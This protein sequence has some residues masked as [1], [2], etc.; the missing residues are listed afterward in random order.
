MGH[1]H[2]SAKKTVAKYTLSPEKTSRYKKDYRATKYKNVE[3]DQMQLA[4]YLNDIAK[5]QSQR[6]EKNKNRRKNHNKNEISQQKQAETILPNTLPL[7]EPL[8]AV[9]N[10]LKNNSNFNKS[11]N[12]N[13]TKELNISLD[14]VS[15]VSI[16]KSQKSTSIKNFEKESEESYD[17]TNDKKSRKL[18]L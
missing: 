10:T 3:E 6:N 7:N 5:L 15:S 18:K 4:K 14:K 1:K 12:E 2:H 16:D 17:N 8:E 9:E 13:L 11:E